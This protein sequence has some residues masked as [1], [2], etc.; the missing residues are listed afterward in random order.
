MARMTL[1]QLLKARVVGPD[2]W[3]PLAKQAG[4]TDWQY[5]GGGMN[6]GGSPIELLI[7]DANKLGALNGYTFDWQSAGPENTGTLTAYDPSGNPVGS[8]SQ[9]DQ[10]LG[11]ALGEWAALAGAGFGGLAL[12][13]AGPL[14]GAFGGAGGAA[15]G[16]SAGAVDAA[17]LGLDAGLSA[18]A[19]GGAITGGAGLVAP[20]VGAGAGIGAGLGTAGAA[21][22]AGAAG[23]AGFWGSAL[24]I[25]AP[26]LGSVAGG[27]IQSNAAGKAA[28]AQTAAAR[29]G[30]EAIQ[31]ALAPYQQAGAQAIGGQQDLLGLNGPAKQQAAIDAI[32][33]SPAFT[34]MQQLGENRILANASATGGLRGGNVQGALAQFSPALLSQLID[35]QYQRLGG[36]TTTGANAAAGVGSA[37]ANLQGQIGSAQAGQALANGSALTNVLGSGLSAVGQYLGQQQAA[38]GIAPSITT[39]TPFGQFQLGGGF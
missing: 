38:P 32:R 21:G 9:Q 6:E 10:S 37:T 31:K 14:A 3:N 7:P 18:G 36:L 22:A 8:F 25:A 30:M 16:A 11:S 12:A 33:T 20:T 27:L 34:S 23:S 28:N 26:V 1:D 4:I 19:T 15:G 5:S 29:A 2:I 17:A 35:Q 24:K 13:G 39:N